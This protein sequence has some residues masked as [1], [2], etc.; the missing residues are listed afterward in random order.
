MFIITII[1]PTKQFSF[2]LQ[3]QDDNDEDTSR[4]AAGI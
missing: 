4:T 1:H 2:R 3:K